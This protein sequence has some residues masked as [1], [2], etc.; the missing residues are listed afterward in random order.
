MAVLGLLGLSLDQ[1]LV[2]GAWPLQDDP[3]SLK[4]SGKGPSAARQE[5]QVIPRGPSSRCPALET[6]GLTGVWTTVSDDV[7]VVNSQFP[8]TNLCGVSHADVSG[9][10]PFCDSS[11][12]LR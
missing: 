10:H 11:I 1:H 9:V 3:W 8:R 7:S 4:S 6:A 12:L 5:W 2:P